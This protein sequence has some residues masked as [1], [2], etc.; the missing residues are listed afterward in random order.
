[1]QA[2]ATTVITDSSTR[3]FDTMLNSRI[4]VSRRAFFTAARQFRPA[5]LANR[6]NLTVQVDPYQTK[7]QALWGTFIAIDFEISQDLVVR[8]FF[9]AKTLSSSSE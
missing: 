5:K 7:V 6:Y 8:W 1:M 9:K 4:L 2:I 3:F